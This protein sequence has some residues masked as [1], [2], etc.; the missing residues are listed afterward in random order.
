MQDQSTKSPAV[1]EKFTSRIPTPTWLAA[2]LLLSLLCLYPTLQNDWVNWDDD[3]YV[4]Q[5]RLIR[6]LSPAGLVHIFATPEKV[7]LY[8]PLTLLS[9]AIDHQIWGN[10]AFGFH[11]T[12]LLLHFLNLILVFFLAKKL[13]KSP[14]AAFLLAL[15]FAIHPMHLES[16]AW[17]SARK[18]LLSG[19]FFWGG[20]LFFIQY[21]ENFK[22]KTL[23]L[24]LLFFVLALLSKAL[25]FTFP[26]ILLLF[27]FR[28]KRRFSWKLWQ[29]KIPF[30]LLSLLFGL[31]A[32]HGQQASD[33]LAEIQ[34]IPVWQTFFPGTWNV[35]IYLAKALVPFHLSP[36][37]PFP[38][39]FHLAWYMVA[40]SLLLGL[41]AFFLWKFRKTHPE[42]IFA[43]A[44]FLICLGPV[45][46]ILPFGKAIQAERYTY[47]A[48]FGLF[49]G[50]IYFFEQILSRF[51]LKWPLLAVLALW[52]F[53]LSFITHQRA[54]I[55]KNGET[56]WTEVIEKYPQH[57][58]GYASRGQFRLDRLHDL[59][60]AEADLRKAL[61]LNPGSGRVW[62]DL[63]RLEEQQKR[64]QNAIGDYNQS[65]KWGED[66]HKAL[67]NR[68]RLRLQTGDD[69]M[70]VLHDLDLA[71]EMKP[72]YALAK[73][74][75]ATL[76][77]ALNQKE[78]AL[79][80][81]DQAILLEPDNA[82]FWQ[83]RGLFYVNNGQPEQGLK[84]YDESLRLDSSAGRTWYLRGKVKLISGQNEASQAD[85][86]KAK[87]L[88]YPVPAELISR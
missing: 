16:V 84:N 77:E 13:L 50:L 68:A 11:L 54:T 31:L 42:W 7:G 18:D 86:Q 32:V 17:I 28:V 2:L 73:L 53:T 5:N 58:F 62:Y 72:D 26:V 39:E 65:I 41:L 70:S 61:D 74:N 8:H 55:W 87:A 78:A 48:Y 6:D 1:F 12:N 83:Y 69:P 45:L 49:Y 14:F 38:R 20:L 24:C 56:L 79:K 29:E 57:Y 64:F 3:E 9:L 88:G 43:F 40:A 36:F 80:D 27:D 21:L 47:L 15:L 59:E 37:H 81:Y 22:L 35:V 10:N 52:V 66:A 76:L 75:R 33:S 23:G 82:V 46:Q 71:L 25:V 19:V 51:K 4:L 44:F 34:Q 60:G 30:F 85:F 63:G 67:V